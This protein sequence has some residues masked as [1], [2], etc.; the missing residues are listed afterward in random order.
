MVEKPLEATQIG[1]CWYYYC[2]IVMVCF[3]DVNEWK[4]TSLLQVFAWVSVERSE[5]QAVEYYENM[6]LQAGS[7]HRDLGAASLN[8]QAPQA[9]YRSLSCCFVGSASA[10]LPKP[11]RRLLATPAPQIGMSSAQGMVSARILR[12]ESHASRIYER[13]ICV[14]AVERQSC[15]RG[16]ICQHAHLQKIRATNIAV[17]L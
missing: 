3:A 2:I 11:A 13:P 16:S 6:I 8:L 14:L 5:R 4:A 7:I 12:H 15:C 17:D 1:N 9:N 10:G